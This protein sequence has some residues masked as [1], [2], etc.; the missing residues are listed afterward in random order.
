MMKARSLW[1]DF[2]RWRILGIHGFP[3][4]VG[5][6]RTSQLVMNVSGQWTDASQAASVLHAL[7]ALGR[8]MCWESIYGMLRF[9]L[10]HFDFFNLDDSCH[11]SK[12]S[13]WEWTKSCLVLWFS[14]ADLGSGQLV[15]LR[16]N[17]RSLQHVC[18]NLLWNCVFRHVLMRNA[19]AWYS[20]SFPWGSFWVIF[21]QRRLAYTF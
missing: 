12:Q 15:P 5:N 9:I 17:A 13:Y 10:N 18:G 7:V 8:F 21:M 1:C 16:W 11:I 3:I 20:R 6:T 19:R 2:A 4:F 14:H